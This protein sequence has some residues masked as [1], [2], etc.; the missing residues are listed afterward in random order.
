M[1]MKPKITNPFCIVQHCLKC[2]V[3][4]DSNGPLKLSTSEPG[5]PFCHRS[6]A[7]CIQDINTHEL[8]LVVD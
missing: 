2:M 8:G 4:N 5:P 6:R 1:L 7:C 3:H